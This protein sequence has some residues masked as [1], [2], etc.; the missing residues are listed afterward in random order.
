MV[1]KKSSKKKVSY[2]NKTIVIGVIVL[3]ILFVFAFAYQGSREDEEGLGSVLWDGNGDDMD[4]DMD[5]GDDMDDAKNRR[6]AYRIAKELI[7]SNFGIEGYT[8]KNLLK[9]INMA[10]FIEAEEVRNERQLKEKLR[11]MNRGLLR[12]FN[13]YHSSDFN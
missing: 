13:L 12:D 8:L 2:N 9:Q 6:E 4:D 3:V 1:K 11:K 5:E 10:N 7:R